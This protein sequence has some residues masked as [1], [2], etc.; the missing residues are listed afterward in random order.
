MYTNIKTFD[1]ACKALSYSNVVPSFENAPEKHRKAL[2]AHYKLIIV[3][4]AANAGWQPDWA[5]SDQLKYELWPDVIA[6]NSKPSGFGLAYHD[7]DFWFSFTCVGS[8]LCFKS[9][10]VAKYTFEQF[11]DLF[12]D[13]ML[14]G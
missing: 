8:R 5:D 13:Y 11:K 9:R 1:D 14:I 10:D 12:E 3:T 6:D 7:Y 2:I 4:E